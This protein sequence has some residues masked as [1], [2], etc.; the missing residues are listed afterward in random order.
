MVLFSGGVA[1]GDGDR[2]GCTGRVSGLKDPVGGVLCI[3]DDLILPFY[4]EMAGGLFE[5]WGTGEVVHV[6]LWPGWHGR[7]K[8]WKGW[9]EIVKC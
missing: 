7:W 5:E 2:M 4:L 1:R 9:C 6:E 8:Y 3:S